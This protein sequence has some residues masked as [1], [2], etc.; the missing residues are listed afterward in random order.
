MDQDGLRTDLPASP[1]TA[2]AA[3]SAAVRPAGSVVA[4]P[5][6]WRALVW[7]VFL[8]VSTGSAW[9][10]TFSLARIA[11]SA[12]A[13]PIGL[14]LWQGLLGGL[15]LLALAAARRR[16]P[17]VSRHH[18]RFY[19]VCGLLGTVIPS[20]LYF[21][22]A[23]RV[24]AGVLS[25]TIALV[26][27]LTFA[28]ALL[29][30]IDRLAWGRVTGLLAGL[31]AV[32]LIVL[33]EESLPDPAMAAWVLLAVVSALCY[34]AEGIYVTLR[35][36]AGGDP[37]AIVAGM[38]LM[39]AAVLIPV[40]LVTGTFVPLG[41]SLGAVEWS[42]IGMVV[43]N[44]AAY[45]VFYHLIQ[46]AGPVFATQMG[47]VVTVAGVAWG[48]VIF[49]EQHSAWV[50]GALVLMLAGLVLVRPQAEDGEGA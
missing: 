12:G 50:W 16:L 39:S 34:A 1:D 5:T 28:A 11:A 10:V 4:K 37:A 25:I 45:S 40:V 15:L 2:D 17:P 48:I 42:V 18:L 9:G 33:P 38:L 24:P 21:Y 20:V 43:V 46:I 49:G 36:P 14:T 8:L 41:P 29:L 32:L 22:A 7:P 27:I 31:G 30:G 35:R 3:A 26:P 19:L 13:H 44:A 47:Y 6:R 23:S